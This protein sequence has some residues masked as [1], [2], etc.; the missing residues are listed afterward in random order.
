MVAGVPPGVGTRVLNF[1]VLLMGG[2]GRQ[3]ASCREK[4]WM[5]Q[6]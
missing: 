1:G 3:N 2:S 6:A 4:K 5:S